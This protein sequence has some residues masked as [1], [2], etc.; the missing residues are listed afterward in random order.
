MADEY[1]SITSSGADD[2]E[3]DT[4]SVAG[5]TPRIDTTTSHEGK[6][7]GKST[8]KKETNST[9][10]DEA[11]GAERKKK[12][13]E[14]V[15]TS[16]VIV[17]G[18]ASESE[19][20][21]STTCEAPLF[22]SAAAQSDDKKKKTKSKKDKKSS[23]SKRSKST[24]VYGDQDRKAEFFDLL[25]LDPWSG[26]GEKL[27]EEKIVEIIREYPQHC[28]EMYNFDLFHEVFP[29]SALCALGATVSTV[30]ACFHAYKDAI[31]ESDALVGT[32]VHY[33]C[34]YKASLDIVKYLVKEEPG[35]LRESNQ[36]ARMPLHM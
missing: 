22:K 17:D 24:A 9:I 6:D 7:S 34:A 13:N 19:T 33:A 10:V 4:N 29:L 11:D 26:G 2:D 23:R 27:D 36:F 30:E 3:G 12:G 16:R 18:S 35:A 5:K 25:N 8:E 1:S 14:P 31:K 28:R 21:V 15:T 20:L 32:P